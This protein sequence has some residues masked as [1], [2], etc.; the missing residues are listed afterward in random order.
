[1]IHALRETGKRTAGW[2]LSRSAPGLNYRNC[3]LVLAH[4]RCGSTALSNILCSREDVSGYGEAHVA[5][6]GQGALGR[7]ALNQMRRGGWKPHGHLLVDKILHS[8]HDRNVPP[9]FFSARA[10]FMVRRPG[11][12][13]C[14]IV[15]L[16]AGIGRGEYATGDAAA[17]YYIERLLALE[18]LWKRF[19][20]DHR[21]GVTHE[22]LLFDPEGEL[23]RLSDSLNFVPP[24][25][26]RY[27]S[28]AASRKG[29][30]GDPIVSG[31]H[32]RIESTLAAHGR[33]DALPEVSPHLLTEACARYSR[34]RA[35][36]SAA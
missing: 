7:L 34:L 20:K 12:A 29:G 35:L 8:R 25:E 32:N 3:V 24:L 22:A 17:Q 26:N 6:D 31:F 11:D 28:L 2:L 1:M 13:I 10:I 36:F 14:S 9:E 16:F 15:K 18:Q 5:H 4:M 19:P 21:V 27:V 30:G 23:A 33:E